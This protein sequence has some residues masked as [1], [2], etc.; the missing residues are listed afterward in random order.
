MTSVLYRCWPVHADA[1]SAGCFAALCN[2][3]S[4]RRS[5]PTSV[6][7]T[8]VTSPVLS[9]VDY[10]NATLIGIR[11]PA[12]N[13]SWR[14]WSSN[15]CMDCDMYNNCIIIHKINAHFAR[16][17]SYLVHRHKVYLRTEVATSWYSMV[18]FTWLFFFTWPFPRSPNRNPKRNRKLN[19][20]P[21]PNANANPNPKPN[22]NPNPD[23]LAS[24]LFRTISQPSPNPPNTNP[25]PN[26]NPNPNP[27]TKLNS[28]PNPKL[29]PYTNLP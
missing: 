21:N 6:Y 5:V 20:N 17:E 18:T 14:C 4:I 19:P 10:G 7:Q 12:H 27:N 13:S 15:R 1:S 29:N 28:N 9:R 3:R 8:L 26:A 22:T 23:R 11:L 24:H 2:L 16:Y 25:N